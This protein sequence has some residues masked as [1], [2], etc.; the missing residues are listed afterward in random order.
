MK[1]IIIGIIILIFVAIGGYLFFTKKL[2]NA[3]PV[4][5]V[6]STTTPIPTP[7]P[8]AETSLSFSP[9]PI[10]IASPSGMINLSIDTGTNKVNAIQLELSYDPKTLPIVDIFPGSFLESATPLLK[11]IDTKNGKLTYVLTIPPTGKAQSG[12]GTIATLAFTTRMPS[13]QK[14]T[15]TFMPKTLVTAENVPTSVLK[16]TDSATIFFVQSVKTATQ[17]NSQEE[18]GPF[19]PEGPTTNTAAPAQ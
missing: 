15:I 9:N 11:N 1:K 19:K 13:G 4:A 10:I 17:T 16:A 12:K 3:G 6:P 7:T 8:S 18:I 2:G 5:T 14:T